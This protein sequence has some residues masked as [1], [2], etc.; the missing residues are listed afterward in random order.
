MAFAP[1]PGLKLH[2]TSSL[3][4]NLLDDGVG[5]SQLATNPD[6]PGRS[7]LS[8]TP[9]RYQSAME[10]WLASADNLIR[11]SPGL[12]SLVRLRQLRPA[13]CSAALGQSCIPSRG[14]HDL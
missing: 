11:E 5:R 2:H 1:P 3:T 12:C 10:A 7:R 4:A 9:K 8:P 14:R 13:T 6:N